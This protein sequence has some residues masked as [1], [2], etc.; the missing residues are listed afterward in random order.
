MPLTCCVEVKVGRFV[1]NVPC[2]LQTR[3]LCCDFARISLGFVNVHF[4]G[5]LG[6]VLPS[7]QD[8]NLETD[9]GQRQRPASPSQSQARG[10]APA[11]LAWRVHTSGVRETIH[12]PTFILASKCYRPR[13]QAHQQGRVHLDAPVRGRSS[14]SKVTG[15]VVFSFSC[16][17]KCQEMGSPI[18]NVLLRAAGERAGWENLCKTPMVDSIIKEMP[19]R[20]N[21][22]LS[23][24]TTHKTGFVSCK[25]QPQV[26][27]EP[28]AVLN[29]QTP[30]HFLP[31]HA[32]HHWRRGQPNT[33][34]GELRP[35]Q[36]PLSSRC[37][38]WL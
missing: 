18:I 37:P 23:S 10:Q 13:G 31:K 15:E 6:D 16:S 12:P 26:K 30:M 22:V 4:K 21:L 33:P 8:R 19:S 7:K 32:P 5:A 27:G 17:G 25:K 28:A 34:D 1:G 2:C 35:H 14:P 38:E 29:T 36:A 11:F 24:V 9:T 20:N 3:T